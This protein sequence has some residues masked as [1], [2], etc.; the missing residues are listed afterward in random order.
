MTIHAD[1]AP[2]ADALSNLEGLAQG[3]G[4]QLTGA[5]KSAATSGRSLE[6]VLRR[7]GLNLAGMALNQGLAPLQGLASSALSS[8]AGGLAGIFGFAKGG[9]PGRVTPFAAGGVVAQ[10]TYFPMSGGLGLMG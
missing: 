4:S 7:I 1:T 3:F 8:F 6:D 2:F 9:V 5:L 10:P